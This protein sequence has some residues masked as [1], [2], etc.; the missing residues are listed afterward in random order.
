MKKSQMEIMGLAIVVIL[1]TLAMAFVI[2]FGV[3]NKPADFK[4]SFTQTELASNMVNTFLKTTSQDCSGLSMTEL[5][6]DC[7]QNQVIYC[8]NTIPSCEYALDTA[9]KIFKRTLDTWNL[10]YEFQV[11]LEEQ[12]PIFKLGNTCPG[13]KKSKLFSIPTSARSLNVKL[14][15]CG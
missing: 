1:I 5:L 2:R 3:L 13:N 7:A 10:A 11:Y 12:N 4:E 14:D 15:I 8:K 9:D 6:Q